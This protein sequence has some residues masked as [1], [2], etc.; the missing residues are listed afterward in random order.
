MV[1][2]WLLLRGLTRGN[3]HWGSFPDQL[4]KRGCEVQ[5]LEIPGNGTQH[6]EDTPVDPGEV[7]ERLKLSCRWIAEKESFNI[8]GISLAGMVA[9]KWAE[10]FPTELNSVAV[11]NTSLARL[12]PFY[13]RLRPNSYFLIL[14]AL[15]CSDPLARERLILAM[16]SSHASR[17]GAL[18]EVFADFSREN[19]V[20]HRNFIRQLLLA[21]QLEIGGPLKVPVLVIS[22]QQDKLV[23]PRCSIALADFL[24]VRHYVHNTSG[25][26]LP[27]DD[28]EWLIKVLIAGPQKLGKI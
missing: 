25:H 19:R 24:R 3:G 4:K 26:D 6:A 11:V 21:N 10:L 27:L 9:L 2:K 5:L 12:S 7:I 16:T 22:S 23:S 8:C 13:D 1:N 18:V 28:P 15:R 20:T 17:L 14:K